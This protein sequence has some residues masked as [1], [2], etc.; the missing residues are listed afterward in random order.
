M[1]I[2]EA[3][4]SLKVHGKCPLAVF[5]RMMTARHTSFL[6]RLSRLR[7]AFIV[8]FL[9]VVFLI[10]FYL[11]LTLN[12]EII[13][14]D[15]SLQ[16]EVVDS[17]I[18]DHKDKYN[19]M[20]DLVIVPGH[21]I[22]ISQDFSRSSIAKDS[23]WALFQYQVQRNQ[24]PQVLDHIEKGVKALFAKSGRLLVFSGFVK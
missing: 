23:N 15:N 24:L 12:P 8:V 3:V 20:E 2:D 1:K 19:H 18:H 17:V 10:S 7:P 4:L 16:E 13:A 6:F 22:Y 21:S 11:L 14:E 5:N 9:L